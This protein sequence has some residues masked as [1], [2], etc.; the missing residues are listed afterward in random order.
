MRNFSLKFI[1]I[2]VGV[3][4]GLGF[5]W[6]PAFHEWWQY[7]AFVFVYIDIIDY[8]IDYEPSL[9]KF[10]PKRE[11]DVLLDVAI[12]F[13]LFLYIYVTQLSWVGYFFIAFALLSTLDFF[14]LLSSKKEYRPTGKDGVFVRTWMNTNLVNA[15]VA[16][17]FTVAALTPNVSALLLLLTFI[18]VRVTTRIV[19]STRYKLV[20][21]R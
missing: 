8:W 17:I 18:L 2:M 7:I 5:Q 16:S 20:H 11:I 6:W 1:D 15:G 21:L 19:A 4:L 12:V 14:W 13:T 9:K 3:V 10:P